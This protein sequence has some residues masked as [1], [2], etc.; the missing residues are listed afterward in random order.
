MAKKNEGRLSSTAI[1]LDGERGVYDHGIA[2][3]ALGEYYTMTKDERVA[4]LL[5]QAIG[6]I[7]DG[8]GPDGGWHVWL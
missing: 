6:Y 2:T 5:K 7:V 8:Q 4:D 3:Y 1:R